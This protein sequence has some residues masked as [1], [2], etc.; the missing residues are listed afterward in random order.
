MDMLDPTLTP[1]RAA[2]LDEALA[3]LMAA[4]LAPV[5]VLSGA[6]ARC[7]RCPAAPL[8]A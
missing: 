5:V 2:G 4:G 8:A 6:L 3:N 1:D 7:P